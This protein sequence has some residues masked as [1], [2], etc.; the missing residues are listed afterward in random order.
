[1]EQYDDLLQASAPGWGLA[2]FQAESRANRSRCYEYLEETAQKV[3]GDAGCYQRFLDVQARFLHYT[4]NNALLIFAQRPEAR[5][6]G[7][8]GYWRQQGIFVQRSQKQHPILILEPGR[9]YQREDG[10]M[11]TY[12]NAKK[13]YDRAQTTGAGPEPK[14]EHPDSRSLI[15]AL[16][17][18]PPAA[19]ETADTQQLPEGA[20]AWF[21]PEQ[22][23]LLVRKGMDA[24]GIFRSVAAEL[25]HAH[26]AREAGGSY[27]R[28]PQD[29][30]ARSAAYLLCRVYGVDPRGL[31][32]SDAPGRLPS[33]NPQEV[34]S[35]LSQIRNT[36]DSMARRMDRVLQQSRNSR[37]AEPQR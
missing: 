4:A 36:A 13:L 16:I 5:K 18:H 33:A 37:E 2:E 28:E 23:R 3:A 9:E 10:T 26:L 30:R 25:V 7:D 32:L 17:S 12:Y 19:I 27:V 29:F 21:V 11:G 34:R 6:L 15:R 20:D 22:R 8:Y 1:M 24:P 14:P 31:D 35:Q